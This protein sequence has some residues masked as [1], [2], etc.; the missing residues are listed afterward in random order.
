MAGS[1]GPKRVGAPGRQMSRV[2]ETCGAGLGP[3]PQDPRQDPGAEKTG[4]LSSQPSPLLRYK[5]IIGS[6][7]KIKPQS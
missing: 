5:T 2:R 1:L 3:G 7:Y 6:G 4:E